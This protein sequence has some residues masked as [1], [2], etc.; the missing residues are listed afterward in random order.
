MGLAPYGKPIYVEKFKKELIDIKDDGSFHLNMSYFNYTVGLTMTNRKF[1][2]LF[3]RP[4]RKRE[5]ELTQFDMDMASSLQAITE[6]VIIK[7]VKLC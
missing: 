3:G 7:L 5:S 4:P 1:D 2:K 6:E